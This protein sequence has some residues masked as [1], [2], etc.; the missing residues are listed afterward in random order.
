[1]SCFGLIPIIRV[2]QIITFGKDCDVL[3]IEKSNRD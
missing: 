3:K 2:I 1:M